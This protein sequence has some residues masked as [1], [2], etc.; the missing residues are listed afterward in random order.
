MSWIETPSRPF[1]SFSAAAR[2]V[3]L[4]G[5]RRLADELD[6]N[7]LEA[8]RILLRRGA[9]LGV[10]RLDLLAIGFEDLAVRLVRP[11]RLA[12]G[13]QEVAGEARLHID[14]VADGAEL[15]DPL[16]Q[17][18]FHCSRS[19][20]HD[21]G[22]KAEMPRALDRLGELALLLGR[23][24]GDAAGDDLAALGHEALEQADVLIV[25]PGSVL[26]REG[27][28]LAAAADW[29]RHALAPCLLP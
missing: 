16:E 28:A 18:D 2:A 15:L 26:A 10:R 25:D 4:A 6:R 3:R 19:L 29:A 9:A 11:E 8:F 22:E 14:H 1:E 7:A 5:C 13:Q 12:V 24:R 17:D 23:H 20:F 21:V 27:A